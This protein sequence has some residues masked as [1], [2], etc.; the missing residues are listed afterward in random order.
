VA[1]LE[2]RTDDRKLTKGLKRAKADS[3][4]LGRDLD[5]TGRAA[6]R[7]GT[8]FRRAGL[9]M[10]TAFVAVGKR[11][12]AVGLQLRNAAIPLAL[13]G[14]AAVKVGFEFDEALSKIVGLVGES[15]EQVDEWRKAILK[16][17]PAVGKGPGELAD[18]LFFITSAGFKGAKALDIL[19][20]SARAAAGG[21]GDTAVVADAVTNAL[22]AYAK[23]G[24]EAGDATDTL[25]AAIQAAKVEASA[26]APQLGRIL[27]L[28]AELGI[29][30][31]E[32]AG[33]LALLTKQSGDAAQATVGL[34][35]ILSKLV[36]PSEQ[37]KKAL[38]DIGLTIDDLVRSIQEQ[39][40]V[41][42]LRDLETRFKG[43]RELMGKVFE[44]IEGLLGV[45]VLLGTD[46]AVVNDVQAIMENRLGA[47]DRAM[48]AQVGGVLDARQAWAA[49]NVALILVGDAL[50]GP[51]LVGL[52]LI[53]EALTKFAETGPKIIEAFGDMMVSASDA[54]FRVLVPSQARAN[55]LLD[56]TAARAEARV[57]QLRVTLKDAFGGEPVTAAAPAL[58]PDA[59]E[60]DGVVDA[61]QINETT[62]AFG[63]LAV[64]QDNFFSRQV[65]ARQRIEE[66]NASL[67]VQA[68]IL[69]DKILTPQQQ[70][71]KLIEE[72][73]VLLNNGKISREQFTIAEKQAAEALQEMTEDTE[74]A[75]VAADRLDDAMQDLGFT[76]TSAFEDAIIA[77]KSFQDVLRGILEDI[78]RIALRRAVTEPL[79]G[80]VSGFFSNLDFGALFG[81]GGSIDPGNITLMGKEHGGRV[82][83]R[84]L[85]VTGEGGPEIFRPDVSGTIIPNDR[86]GMA[87]VTVNQ[88]FDFRGSELGVF[89][90]AHIF[91]AQI[92]EETIQEMAELMDAGGTMAQ[93]SGRRRKR[94]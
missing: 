37:G 26:L 2:L 31:A 3:Q 78:A 24:L 5:R 88:S 8:T 32:T 25:V 93:I 59:D 6:T 60:G 38:A 52:N 91:A 69:K 68:E 36:K 12:K 77:G 55:R 72:Y 23:A 42:A 66:F 48:A 79:A 85:V 17:A 70:Y 40:L 39:G 62:S 7:L 82:R 11:V 58:F 21:L 67:E 75:I 47:T 83:A 44:D 9:K 1:V 29:S 49:F 89:S 18:A 10:R 86:L 94:P 87:G 56:E 74:D 43:N 90:K 76:F 81:G 61:A 46:I 71:N 4:R 27:P 34:R 64:V 80:A 65:A 19:E 28:S 35:G 41:A 73:T 13:F 84:Q 20:S 15:R 57:K 33:A 53:T 51:V 14:A 92:K 50:K 16:L 45:Y 54:L 22:A 30:F 63:S